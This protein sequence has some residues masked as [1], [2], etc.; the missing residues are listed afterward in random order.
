MR[1][2]PNSKAIWKS[3][4]VRGAFILIG[5][6]GLVSLW[7]AGEL[8][9]W[10]SWITESDFAMWR[11]VVIWA[12]IPLAVGTAIYTAFLFGQAEGRDLWQSALL[13]FHLII[14]SFIAGSATLLIVGSMIDLGEGLSALTQMTFVGSLALDLLVTLLGEF[15]MPHASEA[16]A[17]AAHMITKGRYA[18]SF[19]GGSVLLGHLLPLG[20]AF[21]LLPGFIAGALA[22][23]GL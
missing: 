1:I 8:A 22:L 20:L 17:K 18:R 21:T 4:L 5:F 14:Q 12:G 15:G 9:V 2:S 3:W 23:F 6:S 7:W 10:M 16:A 11:E 13:P 19:W